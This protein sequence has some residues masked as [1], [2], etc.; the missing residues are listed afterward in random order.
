MPSPVFLALM[1]AS[2]PAGTPAMLATVDRSI[3][4]QIDC[5]G[6]KRVLSGSARAKRVEPRKRCHV[7]VPILM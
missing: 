4:V 6:K 3:P 5:A 2:S 7:I 1:L